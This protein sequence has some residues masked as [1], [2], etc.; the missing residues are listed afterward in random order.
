M[1]LLRAWT[2]SC[3]AT[4]PSPYHRSW[5]P[6]RYCWLLANFLTSLSEHHRHVR[7]L[8]S[9]S[10][11]SS[12]QQLHNPPPTHG[13]LS[14]VRHIRNTSRPPTGSLEGIIEKCIS[15][16]QE[17]HVITGIATAQ[18]ASDI[19]MAQRASSTIKTMEP[20]EF[21][22]MGPVLRR[23]LYGGFLHTSQPHVVLPPC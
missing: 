10:C 19:A 23:F 7:L 9:L 15:R 18:R 17:K 21:T 14:R 16:P 12:I 13:S 20:L 4:G 2:S 11:H 22:G 3:T 5:G 1:S 8:T 6:L